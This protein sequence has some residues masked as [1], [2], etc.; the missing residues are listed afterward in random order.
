MKTLI[1]FLN[2]NKIEYVIKNNII[3]I[4]T[5]EVHTWE[6]GYGEIM[7]LNGFI[8]IYKLESYK[9]YNYG[10]SYSVDYSKTAYDEKIKTVKEAKMGIIKLLKL[11]K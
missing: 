10:I 1:K 5:K 3:I 8:R 11:E 7:K 9:F 4:D 2:E 6:N